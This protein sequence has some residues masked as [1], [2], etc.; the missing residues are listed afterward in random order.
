M[1]GGFRLKRIYE[2]PA[3]QDGVRVLVDRLWPRG[4]KKE[5]AEI[6]EWDKE[7]APSAELR[8]WFHADQEGRFEE[9]A[10]RYRAELQADEQQERLAQL[11]AKA[12]K[13]TVTLLTGAADAEHGYLTVLLEELEQR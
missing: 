4:M 2:D 12:A 1:A 8:K 9:F 13:S 6:D 5:R 7:L 3:K 11:R 10:D